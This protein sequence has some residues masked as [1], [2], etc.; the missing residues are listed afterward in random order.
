[1][2]TYSGAKS[3]RNWW[4][5]LGT[6]RTGSNDGMLVWGRPGDIISAQCH[7]KTTTAIPMPVWVLW[8][9]DGSETKEEPTALT[10]TSPVHISETCLITLESADKSKPSSHLVD[11]PLASKHCVSRISITTAWQSFMLLLLQESTSSQPHVSLKVAGYESSNLKVFLIQWHGGWPCGNSWESTQSRKDFT[12]TQPQT[13]SFGWQQY[14]NTLSRVRSCNAIGCK[15][16][17]WM[18]GVPLQNQCLIG[19]PQD[20]RQQFCPVWTSMKVCGYCESIIDSPFGG[21]V[22]CCDHLVDARLV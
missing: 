14:Q 11:L 16:G 6:G 1:M 10:C 21:T 22:P 13:L 3:T 4:N 17:H 15:I 12:K 20:R 5:V 18:T 7:L 9:G 8:F 19:C 2:W